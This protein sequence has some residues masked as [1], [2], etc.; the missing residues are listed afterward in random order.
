MSSFHTYSLAAAVVFLCASLYGL[1]SQGFS[2]QAV[3]QSLVAG[4]SVTYHVLARVFACHM[5][6]KI[7]GS[8]SSKKERETSP[9]ASV[10]SE[11]EEVFPPCSSSGTIREIPPLRPSIAT[12]PKRGRSMDQ[13][14]Q[15]TA[16]WF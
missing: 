14:I 3:F 7:F 11:G 2:S 16:A 15:Y 1:G 13:A 4:F 6:T 9:S 10:L 8:D 5:L 12:R